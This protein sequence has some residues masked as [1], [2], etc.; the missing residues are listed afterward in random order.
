MQLLPGSPFLRELAETPLPR[1]VDVVSIGAVRD[2]L[3]PLASTVLEGVRHIALP[4][5]HSGL[6]VDDHVF[7]EDRQPRFPVARVDGLVVAF[8]HFSGVYAPS[9]RSDG[10]R[11][12]VG[13]GYVWYL[14]LSEEQASIGA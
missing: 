3:A 8:D 5:G 9:R 11:L 12:D 14:P 13:R 6:L 7:V 4:T 1:D 2:W 10:L